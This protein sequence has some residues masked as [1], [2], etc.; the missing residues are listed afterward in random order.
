[1]DEIASDDSM[2]RAMRLALATCRALPAWEVDDRPLRAELE[3]R[4]A[5]IHEPPWDDA[6]VDW[7]EFDACLIRTTWD[8]MER[9][10][11]YLEWA[12]RVARATQL[13]NPAPV[14]RWNLHKSYLRDL[15]RRG[16]A[17]VPTIWLEAG[18]PAE[19]GSILEEKGWER[20]FIKPM[21]GANARESLR[22]ARDPAGVAA[23]QAH[24]DRLLPFEGLMLQPYLDRVERDGEVS[25]IL[26]DGE[27]TH[28]VRKVPVSGDY[29]VQDDFGARDY[30]FEFAGR[31]RDAAQAAVDAAQAALGL[32][33]PPLYAR[34]D[35]LR[36]AGDDLLLTELELVEPS[37]FFRHSPPA[38]A[39]LADALLTRLR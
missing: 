21:V 33:R 23:A 19:I 18:Q 6:A 29:R 12:D 3:A 31:E 15:E 30:P 7:S 26:V 10:A 8:Y 34:A 2:S 32:A 11:E 24:T 17:I 22:F 38:A 25:A 9:A 28:G 36:A 1:M 35:F 4:G 16:V 39:R 27:L 13:F 37:L 14:V 20:A 5:E